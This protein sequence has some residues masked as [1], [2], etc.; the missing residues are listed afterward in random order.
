MLLAVMLAAALALGYLALEGRGRAKPAAQSSQGSA[1]AY[2]VVPGVA[3]FDQM[4]TGAIV[5]GEIGSGKTS[6]PYKTIVGRLLAHPSKPAFLVLAAKKG[7][8]KDWQEYCGIAGRSADLVR[9]APGLESVDLLDTMLSHPAATVRDAGEMLDHLIDVEKRRK[10]SGGGDNAFFYDYASRLC[11]GAI[12]LIWHATGSASLKDVYALISDNNLVERYAAIAKEKGVD[13][14]DFGMALNLFQ[15]ELKKTG[16]RQKAGGIAVLV[17]CLGRFMTQDM[18]RIFSSGESTCGPDRVLKEGL[19]VV[20]DLPV[21][22]HGV[23]GR[24]AQICLKCLYQ[25]FALMRS[26]DEDPRALVIAADEDQYFVLPNQDTLVQSVARESRLISLCMTQSIPTLR[27]AVG[28]ESA[29]DEVESLISNH[30][31]KIFCNGSDR[32]T[33]FYA[34]N[35]CGAEWEDIMGGSLPSQKVEYNPVDDWTGSSRRQGPNISWNSQYLPRLR[36]EE[37]TRLVRG[38]RGWVETVCFMNGSIFPE[39]GAP[40]RRVWFDQN[41]KGGE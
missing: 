37:L 11:H 4:Y 30:G 29:R 15:T 17:N 3:T 9:F 5:F 13:N 16:D 22:T 34:S 6:G 26:G 25:K 36:P 1:D 12:S 31:L 19:V 23:S 7:V 33:N 14:E 18:A 35:L 10:G 27:A 39:T 20:A 38:G 8:Y 41:Y 40:F 21:L 32:E 28:G 2:E 24:F